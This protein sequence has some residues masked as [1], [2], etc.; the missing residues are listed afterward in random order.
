MPEYKNLS[1]RERERILKLH[2]QGLPQYLIAQRVGRSDTTVC[3]V[4]R[5]S[6]VVTIY[7]QFG[8]CQP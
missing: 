3:R 8:P 2:Q 7:D 5:E 6:Q 1:P 4:I